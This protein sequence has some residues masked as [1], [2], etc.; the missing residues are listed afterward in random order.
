MGNFQTT[1][2]KSCDKLCFSLKIQTRYKNF[3]NWCHC[4][5]I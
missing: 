4:F 3:C 2:V 5:D 1:F